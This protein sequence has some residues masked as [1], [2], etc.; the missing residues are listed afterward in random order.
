[1]KIVSSQSSGLLRVPLHCLEKWGFCGKK[2]RYLHCGLKYLTPTTFCVIPA[3]SDVGW[4]LSALPEEHQ[5]I[6]LTNACMHGEATS[7]ETRAH[8]TKKI[9]GRSRCLFMSSS[10]RARATETPECTPQLL[11]SI[12]RR[13]L[14]TNPQPSLEKTRKCTSQW[15]STLKPP[16][17]RVQKLL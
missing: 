12:A 6:L 10:R 1:M 8:T 17:K 11:S 3:N 13:L 15:R 16:K 4:L 9:G 7:C 5:F 14:E 2:W